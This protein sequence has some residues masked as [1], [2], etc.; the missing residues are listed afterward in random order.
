MAR[1]DSH[2]ED[3][4]GRSNGRTKPGKSSRNKKDTE[5]TSKSRKSKAVK[6][7]STS[8]NMSTGRSSRSKAKTQQRRPSHSS[9][10]PASASGFKG[11]STQELDK[12]FS[13]FKVELADTDKRL[14][15]LEMKI[16]YEGESEN[17]EDVDTG[18]ID[19]EVDEMLGYI[20]N[21]DPFRN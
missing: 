12:R 8:K 15:E 2:H 18:M 11:I 10:A 1:V 16:S 3:R 17:F 5:M 13:S 14:Q 20:F 4:A 9:V 21:P 19:Y 7:P 6:V